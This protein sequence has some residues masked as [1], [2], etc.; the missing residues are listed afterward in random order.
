MADFK[1]FDSA[2]K[3]LI[4]G[5][6]GF[7]GFHLAK[8]LLTTGATI[9]GF[10]NLNDYYDVSLKENRLNILRQFPEFTFV[11]GDLAD[12]KAVNDIFESFQPDIVVNLA[13]Q[14]GVVTALTIPVPILIPTSSV[15]LIFS[16]PAVI[17]RY[18][19]C[20][21]L[22]VHRFMAISR[23]LLFRRRTMLTIPSVFMRQR[24]NQTN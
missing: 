12:E 8:R 22:P 11:K 3:V 1:S 10:D 18:P 17:I 19:I 23:R 20:S 4:T 15:S 5:V 6:A 9:F 13:A 14:A 2:N 24:K 7:I 21:L 16:K